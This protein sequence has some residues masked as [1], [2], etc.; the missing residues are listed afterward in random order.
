[1]FFLDWHRAERK[2]DNIIRNHKPADVY[3]VLNIVAPLRLRLR[4]GERSLRL[5]NQIMNLHVCIPSRTV[6]PGFTP[7]ADPAE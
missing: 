4:N 1:M 7:E 2:L 3:L 6:A 5:F